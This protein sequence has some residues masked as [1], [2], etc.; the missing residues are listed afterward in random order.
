MSGRTETVAAGREHVGLANIGAR[1]GI[2]GGS[3]ELKLYSGGRDLGSVV[4]AVDS[5]RLVFAR[6]AFSISVDEHDLPVAPA[7]EIPIGTERVFGTFQVFNARPDLVLTARWLLDG[8][9]LEERRITW[10]A[11]FDRGP[12]SFQ[13]ISL[14][15]PAGEHGALIP[16]DYRL[17]ILRGA[18]E[19]MKTLFKVK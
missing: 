12:G 4:F 10:E 8:A 15:S 7:Q 16:G 9:L 13:P 17:V 2:P 5:T 1:W 14:S 19:A 6:M 11:D 3:S 18:R